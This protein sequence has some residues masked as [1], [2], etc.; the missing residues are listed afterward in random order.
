MK[1]TV[2]KSLCRVCGEFD[3]LTWQVSDGDGFILYCSPSWR[4]AIT[5]AHDRAAATRH[6]GPGATQ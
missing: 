1:F 4:R 3:E 5:Y 6:R 2:R